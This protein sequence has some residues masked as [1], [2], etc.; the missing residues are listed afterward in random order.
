M[1]VLAGVGYGWDVWYWLSLFVLL[2]V[3]LV[4]APLILHFL[5]SEPGTKPPLPDTDEGSRG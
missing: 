5:G 1:S 3:F 4:G 2:F